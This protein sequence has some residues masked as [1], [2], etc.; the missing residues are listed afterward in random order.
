MESE[1]DQL[2]F[3]KINLEDIPTRINKLET[4][5][6]MLKKKIPNVDEN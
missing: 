5:C 4:E 1:S 6:E 2:N 3:S